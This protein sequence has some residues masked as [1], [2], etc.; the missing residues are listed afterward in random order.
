MTSSRLWTALLMAALAGVFASPASAQSAEEFFRTHPKLVLGVPAGAGGTY[1][2]YTRLLAHYLPKYIPG[3]PAVAV[4]NIAAAGGLVLANQTYN[5]APKDG[6]FLAMVRGSTVQEH[7]NGNPAALFDGRK[8]AWIGNMNM[9]YETCIALQDSPI[10]AIEDLYDHE[11]IVGASGAGAQSYSFPLVYD[12]VLHM[13]FKVIT[14]YASTPERYLAME[15]GEL[16]GNCGINT[17]AIQATL[18]QQYQQGKIRVLLQAAMRRDPRFPDAPNVRDEAKSEP[19]R[20][21]LDYMFATL[22]LGR[23]FATAG[24]TP[25]DRIALLRRAFAQTMADPALI[26]EAAKLQLDINTMDGDECAASVARLYATPRSVIDRVQMV[27]NAK[28]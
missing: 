21:A 20:Q 6:T 9:E 8:L 19:D 25:P 23:P 18:F 27:V 1:D 5:T 17:S 22:E 16:S 15:R 14:G 12:E 13:K 28:Q 10:R 24:E 2:S 26:E 7:V 11:I 3:T 4:Q